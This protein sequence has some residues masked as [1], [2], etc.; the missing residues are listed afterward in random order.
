MSQSRVVPCPHLQLPL[1]MPTLAFKSAASAQATNMSLELDLKHEIVLSMPS[2][3]VNLLPEAIPRDLDIILDP[4][5]HISLSAQV[6]GVMVD[7]S[8]IAG[9][10]ALDR[11][12]ELLNYWA[13]ALNI[14]RAYIQVVDGSPRSEHFA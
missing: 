13:P 10:A 12:I 6:N 3:K 9:S 4:S 14:Q 5:F 8:D 1:S 2:A 11:M 7:D